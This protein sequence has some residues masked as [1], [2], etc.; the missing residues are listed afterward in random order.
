VV[1][2]ILGNGNEDTSQRARHRH[3]PGRTIQG[4]FQWVVCNLAP[5]DAEESLQG[6]LDL[7]RGHAWTRWL[8]IIAIAAL[9]VAAIG[10][11]VIETLREPETRSLMVSNGG[12]LANVTATDPSLSRGRYW[13]ASIVHD[14]AF[15]G[16][17]V[18]SDRS[19]IKPYRFE[20]QADVKVTVESYDSALTAETVASL[21]G[22]PMAQRLGNITGRFDFGSFRVVLSPD[23][24]PVPVLRVWYFGD[25]MYVIDD[26]V[27][28]TGSNP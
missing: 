25:M 2:A 12:D 15:G 17:L 8:L 22:L 24:T 19:L 16:E 27:L 10:N 23:G 20:N 28:T 6:R 18:V 9:S 7:H 1:V 14:V 3:E 5:M 11:I 21:Q 4:P 13:I 26:R